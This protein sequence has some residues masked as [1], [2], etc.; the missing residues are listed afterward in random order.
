[1]LA[2]AWPSGGHARYRGRAQIWPALQVPQLFSPSESPFVKAAVNPRGL[3][4]TH[5]LHL[6]HF[7]KC[8]LFPLL[9]HLTLPAAPQGTQLWVFYTHLTAGHRAS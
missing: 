5:P 1:M 6:I 3:L 4:C 7:S 9:S 2:E 8:S